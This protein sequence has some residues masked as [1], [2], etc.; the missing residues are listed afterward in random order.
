[1]VDTNCIARGIKSGMDYAPEDDFLEYQYR[2]V[3]K[4]I[5]GVRT[6]LIALGKEYDLEHDYDKLHNALVDLELNLKL[7]NKLKWQIDL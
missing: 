1:M 4:R 5:K 7:W 6:S 2:M 3:N